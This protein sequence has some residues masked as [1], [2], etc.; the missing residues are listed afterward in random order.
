MRNIKTIILAVVFTIATF[1]YGMGHIH[2]GSYC[3]G[4]NG[5]FSVCD[6]S[7]GGHDVSYSTTYDQMFTGCNICL[8]C[9]YCSEHEA[10]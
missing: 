2:E 4:G 5:S 3:P 1:V 7:Y 10:E 8:S 6:S 9:E